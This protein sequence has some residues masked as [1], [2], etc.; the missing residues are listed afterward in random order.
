MPTGNPNGPR[1]S[2]RFIL[3]NLCVPTITIASYFWTSE[4]DSR[5]EL[6]FRSKIMFEILVIAGFLRHTI[7]I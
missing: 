2:V 6:Q 1:A 7:W 4:L 3:D 5:L